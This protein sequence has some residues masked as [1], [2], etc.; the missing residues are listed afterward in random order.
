VPRR[1]RFAT[2]LAPNMF[3]VYEFIAGYIGR[4]L[5]VDAELVVGSSLRDFKTGNADAAFICGL[6][7]VLLARAPQPV[8]ELLAA[9]VLSEDRYQDRA[10]YFSDIIVRSDGAIWSMADL[11]GRSWSYNEPLSHSGYNVVRYKL[12]E[13]GETNGFFGRVVDA[14]WHQKS[15]QMVVAGE[16]EGSA[17]DSQVLAIEF[18]N[19]PQLAQQLRVIDILGPST[20]QPVVAAAQLPQNLKTDLASVLTS[21]GSDPV[22]R[23]RLAEGFIDRFAPIADSDYDDIRMMLQSAEAAGFMEI[24]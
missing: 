21:M 23:E 4:R 9:P 2:F 20:I 17:I 14:G 5:G 10:I 18:R 22:A 12:L 7:Y 19:E 8:V 1:L 11:R 16:V 3:R 13:M 15:I 6:P 24:R